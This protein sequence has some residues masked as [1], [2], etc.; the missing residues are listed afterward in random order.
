MHVLF[1]S[2]CHPPKSV[3]DGR[4]FVKFVGKFWAFCKLE[5]KWNGVV[6]RCV[7]VLSCKCSQ[8]VR[9]SFVGYSLSLLNICYS[10]ASSVQRS[11]CVH[12]SFGNIRLIEL[13]CD[14]FYVR[15]LFVAPGPCSLQVRSCVSVSQ[16]WRTD[17]SPPD[18]IFIVMY[19]DVRIRW[20][21]PAKCDRGINHTF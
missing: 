5:T 7:F 1:I 4:R 14:P 13:Y 6:V 16:I 9:F 2:C 18:A 12:Y 3:R 21:S 19:G 8:F 17:D 11:V 15:S 20:P 10:C